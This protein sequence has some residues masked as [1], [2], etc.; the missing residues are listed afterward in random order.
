VDLPVAALRAVAG[1]LVAGFLVAACLAGLG[2]RRGEL[3]VKIMVSKF[4]KDADRIY[5]MRSICNTKAN[6]VVLQ[7]HSP[8][9]S[10][11]SSV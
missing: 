3:P 10:L 9:S 4:Q 7:R 8:Q 1:L 6:V 5:T 11:D 2:L